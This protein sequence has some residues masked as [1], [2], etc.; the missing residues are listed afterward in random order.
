MKT[1]Q[2]MAILMVMNLIFL[3]AILVP[4]R[5]VIAQSDLGVLRGHSFELIDDKGQIRAQINIEE[6]GQVV[7]RLRDETGAVRVKVGAD[8]YGSS[9]VFLD[10]A[11]EPAIQMIAS[12][13]GTQ[14]SSNTTSIILR[15]NNDQKHVIIPSQP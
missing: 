14:Y 2:M 9:L 12:Q 13:T 6:D 8:S 11:T 3:L 4:N 7:L 15:G 10:E 5:D 1:Q